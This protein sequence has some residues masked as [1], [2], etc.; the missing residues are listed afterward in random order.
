MA[1]EYRIKDEQGLYFITCTVHQW[2]DVFKREVYMNRLI[3]SL[4][5]CQKE[6]G[7]KIYAWVI[8]SNPIHLIMRSDKN[9][10]SDIIRD[11]KKYTSSAIYKA[12]VKKVEK[13]GCC[14]Y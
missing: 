2:V 9:N 11:F 1:F 4:R 5:Y 13:N 14:G 3:E 10:L 8:M 6:K 7:V 12:I